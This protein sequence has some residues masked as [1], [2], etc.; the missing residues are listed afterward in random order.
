MLVM[1]VAIDRRNERTNMSLVSIRLVSHLLSHGNKIFATNDNS[2]LLS[3]QDSI[4]L[5]NH[6]SASRSG[7][8]SPR[9]GEKTA[10]AINFKPILGAQVL[11]RHERIDCDES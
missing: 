6:G 3:D 8:V 9:A 10:E 4:Y 5:F 7:V 11:R 1:V 2:E